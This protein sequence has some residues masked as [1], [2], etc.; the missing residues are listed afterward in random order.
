MTT[1][2]DLKS[3]VLRQV[4]RSQ[5]L[6]GRRE[7]TPTPSS[8]L[9]HCP[10]PL[11]RRISE[12]SVEFFERV[13]AILQKQENMLRAAQAEG[14][15]GA[16]TVPPP[17]EHVDQAFIPDR[18]RRTELDLLYEEAVYT[19]VNRVGVP[20]PEHAITDEELFAYLMK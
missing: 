12:E 2:L 13:N 17:Q 11:P 3:S 15:K 19:V 1:L 4:Q 18:I 6:R 20:S 8:P 5:S 10:D 9:T 14:Q 16:C 7:P